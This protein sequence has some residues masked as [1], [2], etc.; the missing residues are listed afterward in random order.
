MSKIIKLAD[1]LSVPISV[2]AA[3]PIVADH[4]QELR[5]LWSADKTRPSVYSRESFG[6]FW[7]GKIWYGRVQDEPIKN[8][9]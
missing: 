8:R 7:D 6:R 3:S 9:C 5:A 4:N 2:V 1:K